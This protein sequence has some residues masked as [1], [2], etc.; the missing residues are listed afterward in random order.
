MDA[1]VA[2]LVLCSVPDQG[3]ALREIRRV[4]RPNGELRYYEHVRAS[5][6]RWARRQ[7]RAEPIWS[8][9][10]GGCHLTRDTL[11]AIK[12]AGFTIHRCDDV[13]FAPWLA[14]KLPAPTVPG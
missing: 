14:A 7:H 1:A 13:P 8:F 4:L 2:S 10:G 12:Q 11:T 3:A 9:F 5:D 6:A